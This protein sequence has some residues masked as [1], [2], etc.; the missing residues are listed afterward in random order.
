MT[1]VIVV[2]QKIEEAR[3]VRSLLVKNGYSVSNACNQGAQVLDVVD[4]MVNGIVVCGYRY[5]DML[6]SEL[7]ESL[8]EGFEMLLIAS[9]KVIMDET[10]GGVVCL[11]MPLKIQDLLSTL[12]MMVEA[13]ERRKK[14]SRQI[15]KIRS[16]EEQLVIDE[17]KSVLME[18]NHMTEP[19]AFRYMQKC[20]M[21]RGGNLVETAQMILALM[22]R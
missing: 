9:K 20:S 18:R 1:N 17:A 13:Q 16:K 12:E 4:G 21:D 5:G 15:P 2:F 11:E 14:R 3:G 6:F 22:I 8:P 7:K 10:D 19:D